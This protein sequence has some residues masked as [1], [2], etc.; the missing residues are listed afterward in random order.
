MTFK[1]AQNALY[2]RECFVEFKSLTSSRTHTG[3]YTVKDKFQTF[4]DKILVWHIPTNTFH[5]IE[6]S[7]IL[8]ITPQ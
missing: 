5:D 1:D 8:S 2:N 7:T 4:G 6:V 3:L